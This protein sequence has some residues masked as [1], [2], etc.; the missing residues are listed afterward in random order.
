MPSTFGS[1]APLRSAARTTAGPPTISH[2]VECSQRFASVPW[3]PSKLDSL[4]RFHARAKGM[5]DEGHLGNEIGEF[6]EFRPG[7]AARDDNVEHFALLP[8]LVQHLGE[9]QI[10]VAQDDVQF[11]Q[12]DEIKG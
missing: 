7:V 2:L 8:Q 10:V 5:L 1:S 12:H 4:L 6:N 3:Q 11:L 9:R